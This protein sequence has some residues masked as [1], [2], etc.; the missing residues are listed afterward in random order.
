MC[1]LACDNIG[2]FIIH[3]GVLLLL[4]GGF[5]TALSSDEGNMVLA[6]NDQSNYHWR[7]QRACSGRVRVGAEIVS[8]SMHGYE[9]A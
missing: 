6:E 8:R 4:L 7:N 1:P 5:V 2:T 9:L 3:L